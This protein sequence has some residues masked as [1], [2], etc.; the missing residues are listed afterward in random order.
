MDALTQLMGGFATALTPGNLVY[1]F[2]TGD[3]FASFL[4]D[5]SSRV[6]SVMSDL[7]LA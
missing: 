4:D 7:G 2:L 3:D 6:Q 1:A 5:E